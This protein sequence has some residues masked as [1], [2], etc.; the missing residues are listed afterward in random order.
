MR[1]TCST[2]CGSEYISCR[3]HTQSKPIVLSCV[4]STRFRMQKI[5]SL[6]TLKSRTLQ[7]LC[8]ES[9][10]KMSLIPHNGLRGSSLKTKAQQRSSSCWAQLGTWRAFIFLRAIQLQC[11]SLARQHISTLVPRSQSFSSLNWDNQISSLLYC[12]VSFSSTWNPT[13]PGQQSWVYSCR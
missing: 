13:V 7:L 9:Q 12:L 1:K 10:A 11:L 5:Q 3:E 8:V 2:I 4:A 6:F